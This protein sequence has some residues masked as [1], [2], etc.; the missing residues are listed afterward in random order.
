MPSILTSPHRQRHKDITPMVFLSLAAALPSLSLGPMR[1]QTLY[2]FSSSLKKCH[3]WTHIP[4]SKHQATPL[5]SSPLYNK[6]SWKSSSCLHLLFCF[7]LIPPKE[8]CVHYY[9]IYFLSIKI[10]TFM[11]INSMV[12]FPVFLEVLVHSLLK[13]A[14]CSVF[15]LLFLISSHLSDL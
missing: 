8:A 1:M 5:Y 10:V 11:L 15:Q 6:T 13:R 3:F 12:N 9:T 4:S 7:L 14:Y 2:Y